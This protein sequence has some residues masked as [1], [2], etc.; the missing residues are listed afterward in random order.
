[1]TVDLGTGDG[2]FVLAHASAHPDRFVVGI[3][4]SPEAMREASRRAARPGS[5]GGLP[6]AR[7]LVSAVDAFPA[8]LGGFA[9]LVTVHF[10]WGSL[11]DAATGHDPAVSARIGSLVRP[12]G[13]LRLLLSAAERDGNSGIHP[14]LVATAYAA[15]GMTLVECRRATLDDAAAVHSSWGK[16]LLR[17]SDPGRSAWSFRL[18]RVAPRQAV[19]D[20]IAP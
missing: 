8:G 17:R 20:R 4:A 13:S 9:D 11:R 14:E 15:L 16:R 6:N 10:P 1:V 5:R 7:F 18:D 3:D 19:G 12:G 2:R